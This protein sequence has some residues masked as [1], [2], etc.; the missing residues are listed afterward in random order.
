M[1]EIQNIITAYEALKASRQS[2]VLATVVHL[3]GSSY[4]RPGARMLVSDT[5]NLTGAISGGCL[6]GDALQKAR[7]AMAR[8]QS[9]IITYDTSDDHDNGLGI[10][11]GCNGIIQV[12]LEP[13]FSDDPFNPVEWLRKAMEK[14]QPSVLV[15]FFN[16]ADRKK[17][18]PGT[19][20]LL[21]ASGQVS[22]KLPEI[23]PVGLLTEDARS[24][25]AAGSSAF[26]RYHFDGQEYTAFHEY[27]P[28]RV[29]LV[30]VGAGNDAIPLMTLADLIGWETRVVDGRSSHAR[31]DRFVSACQVLVSKPEQI[32]DQIPVDEQTVFV[33]MTHNYHYDKALLKIL[34]TKPVQYVGML[35][36]KKKKLKMLDE[37]EAEG[38]QITEDRRQAIY[39][40]VGVDIGAET[41]EEI[42]LSI[43]AEIKAVL[44]HRKGGFLRSVS[45]PIHPRQDL[46]IKPG[47][48]V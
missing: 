13:V 40:P 47:N 17:S 26:H 16:L 28:P 20:L 44:S 19:C 30:I 1:K 10:G 38:L 35:G 32:L 6:E 12:L 4:R 33:L 43:I 8:Q 3:E 11:L 21:E 45:G 24:V 7:L 22:A 46:S 18:Q 27:L 42:A 2:M 39:A 41:S 34:I 15:T 37:I 48:H 5:G 14:R 36:P 25:L 23:L 31:P 9:R 29:R